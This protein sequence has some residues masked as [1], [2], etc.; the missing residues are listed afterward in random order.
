MYSVY[1]FEKASDSLCKIINTFEI[2]EMYIP[3]YICPSVRHAL[4]KT[5]CKP[6]FYHIDDNFMPA[7][8]FDKESYILYPNYFGICSNNVK[9]LCEI[10]PKLIVDNAH[11]FFNEPSGLACFNAGYKFGLEN[12]S[13]LW[14]KDRL[15]SAMG[16]SEFEKEKIKRKKNFIKLCEKYSEANQLE[17][18]GKSI[19]FCYPYLAKTE[20]EAD[21]LAKDLTEKGLAIYRYWESL[22]ENFNEYK[23]YKRLVPIPLIST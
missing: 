3:Y 6:L 11:A 17:I 5:D 8:S 21:K 22:P 13:Y 15:K 7:R 9:Q 2:K 12:C 16:I 14:I 4:F 23:F 20:E 18:D 1:K 10:Y 19:P